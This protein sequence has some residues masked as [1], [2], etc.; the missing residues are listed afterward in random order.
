MVAQIEAGELRVLYFLGHNFKL[1]IIA[2][3]LGH[4][5]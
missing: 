2:V 4:D 5:A 1:K 3:G